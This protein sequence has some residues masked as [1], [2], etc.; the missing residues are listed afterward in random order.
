MP[1]HEMDAT[2]ERDW[3]SLKSDFI[4]ILLPSLGARDLRETDDI[5][6]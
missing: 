4:E 1:D 5:E 2:Y 3:A 6:P